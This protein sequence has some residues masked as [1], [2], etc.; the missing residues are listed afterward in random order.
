ML[1]LNRWNQ[2]Q[3]HLDAN[4]HHSD[5]NDAKFISQLLQQIKPKDI[6]NIYGDNPTLNKRCID[7]LKYAKHHNIITRV[8][9][10]QWIRSIDQEA[11]YLVDELIIWCPAATKAEFNLISGREYFDYFYTTVRDLT[12]NKTLSFT[13]RPMNIEDLPEFY[14]MV[15]FAGA[16][17]LLLYVK[18]EFSAEELRYIKRYNRVDNM[19]VIEIANK[20]TRYCLSR[21][22]T[23]GGLSFEWHDW[24]FNIKQSI[25]TIPLLKY[26][27]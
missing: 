11:A 10:N 26:T 13:V 19:Q 16:K 5:Q 25:K 27:V 21:P 4:D 7:A 23:M 6:L 18:S 20:E 2:F 3:L 12:V 8:W 15:V 22:N 14:D 24:L 9:M 1:H 17:G